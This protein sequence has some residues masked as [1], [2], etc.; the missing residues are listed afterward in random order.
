MGVLCYMLRVQTLFSLV[1]SSCY[2]T[3]IYIPFFEAVVLSEITFY[4]FDDWGMG[5]E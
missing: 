4:L 2:N 1:S 3:V 5:E